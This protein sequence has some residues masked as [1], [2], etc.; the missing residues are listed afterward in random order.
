MSDS[1]SGFTIKDK[2][3][4]SSEGE[5]IPEEETGGG[6]EE[7]DT[8]QAAG[9]M[10]SGSDTGAR[11]QAGP[12]AGGGPRGLPPV[13]FGGF[14]LSLSHA[15]LMHMGQAPDPQ[16]GQAVLNL[17]LARHTI[18]T[19]AMLQDKTKG[20]LDPDEQRLMDNA[21]SQ[22]RMI[23]VQLANAAKQGPKA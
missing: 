18:D 19:L 23:F 13:D 15:A 20:N 11:A 22:L 8:E 12:S 17:D 21:L 3:R 9:D 4:F 6:P 14:I 16:T 10:P 1:D 2:R 7:Q 5:P